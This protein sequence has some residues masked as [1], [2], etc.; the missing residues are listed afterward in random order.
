LERGGDA[1]ASGFTLSQPHFTPWASAR[2]RTACE[3]ITMLGASAVPPCPPDRRNSEYHWSRSAVREPAQRDVGPAGEDAS[4][5]QAAVL[6]SDGR[7]QVGRSVGV[8]ALAQLADGAR[9]D[10]VL[11]VIDLPEQAAERDLGLAAVAPDGAGDIALLAVSASLPAKARTSHDCFPR[12]R[13]DP[14]TSA[15]VPRSDGQE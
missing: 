1:F 13:I 6:G 2:R 15:T 11:A 9:P 12:W 3:R 10:R 5:E 14:A 8:P 7:G 4:V